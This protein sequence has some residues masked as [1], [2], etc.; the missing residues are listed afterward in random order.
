VREQHPLAELT[1]DRVPPAAK[2]RLTLAEDAIQ[3]HVREAEVLQHPRPEA[4][5]PALVADHQ[6]QAPPQA[7]Q[8]MSGQ[9]IEHGELAGA[10]HDPF[11]H[12]VVEADR[13]GEPVVPGS[14]AAR[15]GRQLELEQLAQPLSGERPQRGAP[16]LRRPPRTPATSAATRSKK[17]ACRAS[18][19]AWARKQAAR[20]RSLAASAK[21]SS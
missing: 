13:V 2:R 12:H 15:D 11:E 19:M 1:P 20:A 4:E 21:G 6:L 3:A 5:V 16:P 17:R 18:S 10:E 8:P 9:Q 7:G 14:Q